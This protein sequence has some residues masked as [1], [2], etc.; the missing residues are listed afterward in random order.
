MINETMAKALSNVGE[1][2]LLTLGLYFYLNCDKNRLYDHLIP[3]LLM[4]MF[5]LRCTSV[6]GCVV[7]VVFHI[8]RNPK[9]LAI[10]LY[11]G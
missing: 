7:L 4:V 6:I 9:N 5:T 11:V 8:A 2:L 10:Y 3:F 1:S